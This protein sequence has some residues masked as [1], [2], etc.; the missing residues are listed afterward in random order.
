M[1]PDGPVK[2]QWRA[3]GGSPQS[4]QLR[5]RAPPARLVPENDVQETRRRQPI[6]RNTIAAVTRDRYTLPAAPLTTE[7]SHD[8]L[9]APQLAPSPSRKVLPLSHPTEA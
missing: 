7:A 6:I 1:P 9:V 8:P 5:G 4:A 3:G 2:Q